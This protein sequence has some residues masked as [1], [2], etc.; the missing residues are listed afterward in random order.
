MSRLTDISIEDILVKR[1]IPVVDE[2][3]T[4]ATLLKQI[5]KHR[6]AIALVERGGEIRGV[7][8][9]PQ[10]AEFIV[11][12][13]W[14]LNTV[15]NRLSIRDVNI[16]QEGYQ[17]FK[18]SDSVLEAVKYVLDKKT[19]LVVEVDGEYHEVSPE[20]L[21]SLYLLWEDYFNEKN[22]GLLMEN[23]LVKV[24]PTQ[25]LVSTFNKYKEREL[26]SA[27]VI[28]VMNIPIGIVTNTDYVYS[29]EEIASKIVEIKPDRDIK[30][31]IDI[32][33]TNPVIFEFFDTKSTEA[34][35]KMVEND[36]GHLPIVNEKEEIIGI[37][38]KYGILEELV[39]IDET[40]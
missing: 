2:T 26:D 11:K 3:N 15:L 25:S 24:P 29:Y 36:I 22:I 23:R 16:M 34:L 5:T 18:P 27:V 4:I 20:D 19:S 30:L 7:T 37:I 12:N 9:I 14:E 1:R 21:I 17:I 33:M 8:T 39:R 35:A 40:A 13:L 31:T 32:V 10:L 38:Y 6:V 28:N